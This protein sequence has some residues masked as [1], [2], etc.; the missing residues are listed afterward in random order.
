[1]A[2]EL[3]RIRKQ[4]CLCGKGSVEHVEMTLEGVLSGTTGKALVCL[5]FSTPLRMRGP[6]IIL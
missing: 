2:E 4:A 1:M 5:V 3:V 6:D